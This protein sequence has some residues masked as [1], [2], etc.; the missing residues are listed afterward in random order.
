M[1]TRDIKAWIP[2]RHGF[3]KILRIIIRKLIVENIPSKEYDIRLFLIDTPYKGRHLL[4]V[5]AGMQIGYQNDP[6]RHMISRY[7]I[8]GEPLRNRNPGPG[9]CYKD[10]QKYP[11][12][13]DPAFM[14][15][16]QGRSD[17]LR[18]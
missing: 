17:A 15:F 13:D 3:D 10:C 1:I 4:P 16:Q 2:F 14:F 6:H 18:F 5:I 12:E 11:I 9:R 7:Q 8:K